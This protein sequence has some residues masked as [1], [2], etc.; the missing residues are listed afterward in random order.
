MK[1]VDPS[2]KALEVGPGTCNNETTCYSEFD[3][4]Q[5]VLD[6]VGQDAAKYLHLGAHGRVTLKG[7]SAIN[8]V[9]LSGGAAIIGNL[10]QS[11]DRTA[12]FT[13]SADAK[14]GAF[15]E[16]TE[17]GTLTKI[18]PAAFPTVIGGATQTLDTAM[19]HDLGGH[20]LMDMWGVSPFDAAFGRIDLSIALLSVPAAEAFAV[21][22]ENEY[23]AKQ[24][25][26][27]RTFY[28]FKG[29]YIPPP[30]APKP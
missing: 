18:N 2:G 11:T 21:T 26:D 15:T 22:R 3:T 8:F 5:A 28:L 10:I 27:I 24:G 23:R 4:F 16:P 12:V 9:R 6:F 25:M 7:I 20:A 13:L 1:N 14:G 29:D 30:G 19:A 17:G